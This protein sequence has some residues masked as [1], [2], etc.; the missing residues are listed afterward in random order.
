MVYEQTHP[1]RS[2]VLMSLWLLRQMGYHLDGGILHHV[3]PRLEVRNSLI[4]FVP[5]DSEG[6]KNSPILHRRDL[7]QKSLGKNAPT[8]LSISCDQRAYF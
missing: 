4:V 6:N 5:P 7:V 8:P 3:V 2:E 1:S